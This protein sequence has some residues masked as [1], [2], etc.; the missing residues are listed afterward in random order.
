VTIIDPGG[1]CCG[2]WG[3]FPVTPVD[4]SESSIISLSKAYGCVAINLEY[5]I[6]YII[7]L[8]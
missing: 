8:W 2:I 1:G 4:P 7:E 3:M 6:F 5:E